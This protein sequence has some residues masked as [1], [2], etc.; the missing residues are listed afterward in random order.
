MPTTNAN[1]PSACLTLAKTNDGR[2]LL[3]DFW[4]DKVDFRLLP[5]I[6]QTK[7]SSARAKYGSNPLC[8]IEDA[9]SGQ[10]LLQ[11]LE[12]S[13]QGCLLAGKPAGKS[14][15]VRAEA[16]TVWTRSGCVCLPRVSDWHRNFVAECQEFPL[17]RNDEA[18]DCLSQGLKVFVN[19]GDFKVTGQLHLNVGRLSPEQQA[20]AF[21]DQMDLDDMPWCGVISPELDN[22]DRIVDVQKHMKDKSN[23]LNAPSTFL[24]AYKKGQ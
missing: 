10:Q 8:V 7:W 1:D 11:I 16:C 3:L 17:G 6:V 14:K 19:D 20:Q 13:M 12:S 2:I 21:I 18:V 4:K 22:F 15:F 23:L 24:D 9:S 5:G